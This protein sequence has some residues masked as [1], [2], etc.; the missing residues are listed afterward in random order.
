VGRG[1]LIV[2]N[3]SCARISNMPMFEILQVTAQYSN[4]VLMAVMPYVSDFA[5]KMDLPVPQPVTIS[6]VREF[7][8]SPRSDLFGG[9]V[10]LA[11]HYEFTFLHGRVEMY[12]NPKSFYELQ[13][14][15]LVPK[16]FGPIK[17]KEH[18]A[19]AAARSAIKRM[20]YAVPM[21]SAD[22]DPQVTPPA[23][24]GKNYVAR[25]RVRWVDPT[26][27][28]SEAPPPSVEF[29]VD[30]TTGQIQTMYLFN[31]NTWKADP[32]I[33]VQAPV[34]A[35]GPQ[36]VHRGGRKIEPVSQAYSN[37]FLKAILPQCAQYAATAGFSVRSPITPNDVDTS[38]SVCGLVDDDPMT[39]IDLKSGERFVYRHGQV[40]AFYSSDV[41]QLP[42]R[43][44]PPFPAY[45][46]FQARFYG[47][48]NLTTNE[49]VALVRDTLKRLGYREKVLHVDE[50]PRIGGPNRWGT[51]WIARCILNWQEPDQGAFRAVAEV[52]MAGKK[53]KSLYVND[54]ANTNIWR[55]PPKLGVPA[56]PS[57]AE[58]PSGEPPS[59]GENKPPPSKL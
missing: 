21:L 50:P 39:S 15:D 2:E 4:A 6:H 11:N 13:D 40:I 28:A 42:G 41:M 7:R 53:V 45:E 44:D 30:A 49:A 37:A 56:E 33:S 57:P 18:D 9:R 29:E 32:K 52:D 47:R 23:K 17:L 35:K 16:F 5:R 12:R 24:V 3:D 54:H 19:V 8:C 55:P 22:R 34:A 38:K 27:G 14:P 25:Y 31:P 59:V 10:I 51:N 1:I 20:G 36:T 48:I 46:K 58:L 43:E 26:R